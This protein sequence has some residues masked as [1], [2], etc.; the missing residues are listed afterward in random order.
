VIVSSSGNAFL[1]DCG[2]RRLLDS[3]KQM[4][5][6]GAFQKVEGI[7]VTHYHDDHTN[8][9]ETASQELAAPVYATG[10]MEDVLLHPAAYKIPCLTANPI[11]KVSVVADG[12][13]RRWHEFEFTYTYFPGQTLYHDALLVKKDGGE[14]VLLVGDSFTPTGIDDYCVLNRNF[15]EPEPGY[16][17]CLR[18]IE[19]VQPDWLVNQHVDPAFHFSDEQIETMLDNL[20]NRRKQLEELFPWDDP[21]FG[22]DDQWARLYPYRSS[23]KAGDRVELRF[24]VLNHSRKAQEFVVKPRVPEGWRVS[25]TDFKL[26]VGGRKTGEVVIPI[27]VGAAGMGVVTADVKA[28]GWE[29]REWMEAI[30][31]VK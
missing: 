26:K 6:E 25:G 22:V 3:V 19:K 9:V 2:S 5:R 11:S 23:A 21:N 7:W 29:A 14:T 15:S 8:F 18:Y 30:V 12:S 16:A 4:Q 24:I 10:E 28:G 1:V 13:T 17:Q 27:V 31:D 20:E